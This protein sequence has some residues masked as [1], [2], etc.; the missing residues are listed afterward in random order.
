MQN[1]KKKS[2]YETKN[3]KKIIRFV[4]I[5]VFQRQM[6]SSRARKF[7]ANVNTNFRR[8]LTI[9]RLFAAGLWDALTSNGLNT[10]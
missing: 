1:H 6:I 9:T 7:D 2:R 3:G 8:S 4:S 10:G 5:A